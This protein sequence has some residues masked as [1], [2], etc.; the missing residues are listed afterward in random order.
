M[1]GIPVGVF[2]E[3]EVVVSLSVGGEVGPP[4]GSG[5]EL[6]TTGSLPLAVHRSA[7]H[8]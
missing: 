3:S 4:V 2:P 6:D 8:T 1:E 5:V 7:A